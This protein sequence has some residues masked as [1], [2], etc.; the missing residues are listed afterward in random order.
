MS[1]GFFLGYRCHWCSGPCS[2][3][4]WHVSKKMNL[5][6]NIRTGSSLT[7]SILAVQWFT[8][9]S[10]SNSRLQTGRL[11]KK[12]PERFK[13][14]STFNV[15]YRDLF[16][17]RA[18]NSFQ[19]LSPYSNL[20]VPSYL[21][22]TIRAQ[23]FFLLS[24]MFVLLLSFLHFYCV[25]CSNYDTSAAFFNVFIPESP[26]PASDDDVMM[27]LD[28]MSHHGSGNGR[29]ADMHWVGDIGLS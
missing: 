5:T 13:L 1:I 23:F 12:I 22:A 4:K 14:P 15:L 25:Y 26:Y 29:V 9:T 2:K 27:W 28:C 10:D 17:P 8:L 24:L 16:L 18:K 20:N 6:C 19:N 21:C 3:A 7:C 11:L